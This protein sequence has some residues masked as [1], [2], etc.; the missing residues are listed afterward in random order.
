MK[1]WTSTQLAWSLAGH[2][3][4]TLYVVLDSD[5][6]YVWLADGKRRKLEAPKKKKWKHVQAVRHLPEELLRQMR[7]FTMDAHVRKILADYIR[8]QTACS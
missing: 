1:E 4:G 5:E 3:K 7:S 8:M 6:T 2:D